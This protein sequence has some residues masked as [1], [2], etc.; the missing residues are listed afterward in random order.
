MSAKWL[1]YFCGNRRKGT[2]NGMGKLNLLQ[3]SIEGSVGIL[4]GQ[5]YHGKNT[6]RTKAQHI[7]HIGRKQRNAVRNFEKLNR[8]ASTISKWLGRYMSLDT[9]KQ[10][11]HNAVAQLLRPTL[12]D[13]VFDYSE[14]G[15]IFLPT[16]ENEILELVA[17][18]AT[19]L[20]RCVARTSEPVAT[21]NRVHVLL[22]VCDVLGRSL[23]SGLVFQ[24]DIDISFSFPLE[25]DLETYAIMLTV[26]N[27]QPRPRYK[28]FAMR[29]SDPLPIV[30][31]PIMYSTRMRNTESYYLQRKTFKIDGDVGYQGGFLVY[32]KP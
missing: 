17:D 3:G 11:R 21:D 14:I 22:M 25:Y 27:R 1:K 5:R 4:V 28:G 16:G 6:L 19:Q 30:E 15:S 10:L 9:T 7:V 31:P 24:N 26:D 13:G 2:V 8:V 29:V 18:G 23:Y 32:P 12:H 20:I